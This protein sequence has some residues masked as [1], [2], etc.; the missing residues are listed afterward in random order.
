MVGYWEG[1]AISDNPD[2]GFD[3]ALPVPQ[4]VGNNFQI[5]DAVLTSDPANPGAKFGDDYSITMHEGVGTQSGDTVD[6]SI[7]VEILTYDNLLTTIYINFDGTL[8]PPTHMEGTYGVDVDTWFGP[9]PLRVP[10][11]RG[12]FTADKIEY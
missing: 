5:E 8:T 4:Q 9:R 3:L 1:D 11:D 7:A 6:I 10:L 2:G 12:D